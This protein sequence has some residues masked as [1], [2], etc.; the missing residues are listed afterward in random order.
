MA[1]TITCRQCGDTITAADRVIRFWPVRML[2]YRIQF[3]ALAVP[4]S[5][6]RVALETGPQGRWHLALPPPVTEVPKAC[7]L[8]RADPPS[9]TREGW[10]SNGGDR[11]ARAREGDLSGG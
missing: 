3:I 7:T 1:R 2:Q 11:R 9:I 5:A 4:S 8:E 10:T 6:A